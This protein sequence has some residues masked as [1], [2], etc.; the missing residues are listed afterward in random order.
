MTSKF[1]RPGPDEEYPGILSRDTF[2]GYPVWSSKTR[3]PGKLSREIAWGISRDT[4][5]PMSR[6]SFLGYSR[7]EQHRC[8][9]I[10]SLYMERDNHVAGNDHMR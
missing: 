4:V 3:C 5:G 6:E 1:L 8:P 9:G 7:L 10:V 2:P